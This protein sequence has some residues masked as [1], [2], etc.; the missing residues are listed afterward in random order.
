M[1]QCMRCQCSFIIQCC[2]GTCNLHPKPLDYWLRCNAAHFF[3]C[4]LSDT[5]YLE[6][7]RLV[8]TRQQVVPAT[9]IAAGF[10]VHIRSKPGCTDAFKD[11]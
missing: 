5:Q 4:T 8:L 3:A 6:V 10:A 9:N 11:M 1:Q 2:F 7:T